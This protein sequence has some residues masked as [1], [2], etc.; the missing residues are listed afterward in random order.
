MRGGDEELAREEAGRLGETVGENR[1]FR[2]VHLRMLAVLAR[3]S[4]EL[5]EALERLREAGA[6]ADE[7]GLPGES[8]EIHASV[9]DLQDERGKREEAREAFGLAAETVLTLAGRIGDEKL[10]EGFLSAYQVRRVLERR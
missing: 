2:L 10:R 6:L 7:I 1:R 3:W 5:E 4:G 9:G 8:W